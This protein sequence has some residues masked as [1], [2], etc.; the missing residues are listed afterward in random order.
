[1]NQRVED[2]RT[3]IKS[4]SAEELEE[5]IVNLGDK[6]FRGAQIFQWLHQKLSLRLT[7]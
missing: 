1:M 4:M 2:T 7:R 6:K 5:F 3:D